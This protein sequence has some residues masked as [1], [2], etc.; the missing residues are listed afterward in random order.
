MN[1]KRPAPG[2]RVLDGKGDLEFDFAGLSY[3]APERVRFRYKLEGFDSDWINTSAR[4][5]YYTNVPPGR[6]AF[7][8]AAENN[9]GVWNRQGASFSLYLEPRFYQSWWFFALCG[10]ALVA[11]ARCAYLLR[12]KSMRRRE[13][14]LVEIVADRTRQLQQEIAQRRQA[15][16]RAEAAARAKS[17][18]L[19]IMSHEIRTPLN[20]VIGM[21]ELTHDTELTREQTDLLQM[22]RDSANGLLTLL[23]DILDFS[24]IEAGKLEFEEVAFDLTG[25]IA[26]ACRTMAIRA[27][28]K[29]IEMAYRVPA[30]LQ[31]RFTGDAGRLKQV[32]VNL[33]G[34]AVKFTERGEVVLRV[35]QR[36]LENA[37]E[38]QFS[39]SD[40]GIGI[41]EEKLLS[42][43][44]AFSQA[45]TSVTR[46]FG[47][48][49]L[50]L[51]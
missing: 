37:I 15:T 40:T 7:R 42:I 22:A 30:S 6:Y 4:K 25:V 36:A 34:N 33:L 46:R 47:G 41:P 28:E 26:S 45:D 5:A 21:L 1:G 23:N 11:A 24:K 14:V 18:F 38:L 2:A 32:L 10:I 48:T 27:H 3:L 13:R 44:E 8:V 20:G 29:Q 39:V 17:E 31:A 16:E 51:T 50:G 43:F 9:D 35:E 12:L 49:G 19:A